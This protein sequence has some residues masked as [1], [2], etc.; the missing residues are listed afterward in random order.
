MSFRGV[1]EFG[2]AGFDRALDLRHAPFDVRFFFG[3]SSKKLPAAPPKSGIPPLLLD[4]GNCNPRIESPTGKCITSRRAAIKY[5]VQ[6]LLSFCQRLPA[7][8]ARSTKR[9]ATKANHQAHL[10]TSATLDKTDVRMGPIIAATSF[11]FVV[12]QLDVTI[13]NV[14]LPR[15]ASDLSVQV[16]G[17]QWAVDAYTLPFAVLML[18]AGVLGDRYGSR[19][20]YLIGLAIFAVASAACGLAPNAATLI[21]AR[22][23]QG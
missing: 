3:D 21:A 8:S 14:A 23:A 5:A 9:N 7:S 18:S 20:T 22:A 13:V 12:T 2:N 17:L 15:I 4:E 11:G 1:P 10:M 16:A 19:R 6:Y